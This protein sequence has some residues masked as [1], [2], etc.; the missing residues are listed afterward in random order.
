MHFFITFGLIIPLALAMICQQAS[1]ADMGYCR[2]RVNHTMVAI[3]DT[4]EWNRD[5]ALFSAIQLNGY[6]EW[7]SADSIRVSDFT[8]AWMFPDC[9]DNKPL[10]ICYDDCLKAFKHSSESKKY[11][12]I[13]CGAWFADKLNTECTHVLFSKATTMQITYYLLGLIILTMV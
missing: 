13:Y 7:R 5:I 12:K 2:G 1:E 4:D 6:K 10:P 9:N 3:R 11:Q 8:C